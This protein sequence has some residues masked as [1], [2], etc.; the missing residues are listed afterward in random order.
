MNVKCPKCRFKFEVSVPSECTETKHSCPRCGNLFVTAVPVASTQVQSAAQEPSKLE[1]PQLLQGSEA[2]LFFTA[3]RLMDEGRCK[4]A[5]PYIDTLLD[6]C[7]G[8]FL[9]LQFKQQ[10][11]QTLEEQQLL[12]KKINDASDYIDSEQL[13]IAQVLVNE[14]LQ[15]SPN[16]PRYIELEN[17]LKSKA[18]EVAQRQKLEQLKEAARQSHEEQN[19][20]AINDNDEEWDNMSWYAI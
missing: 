8:E 18:D 12:E 17:R 2:E 16:N 11:Q 19:P 14:L 5:M 6:M 13:G 3:Q 1:M 7:P 10:L 9:Y 20:S 15:V 4:E